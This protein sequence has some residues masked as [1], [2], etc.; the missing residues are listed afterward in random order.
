MKYKFLLLL[1]LSLVLAF[2]FMT[3]I[4]NRACADTLIVPDDCPTIQQAIDAASPGDTIQVKPGTYFEN[5]SIYKSISLIAQTFDADD[6][7][8]NV[9]IIDS[10]EEN[11]VS[12][13]LIPEGISPMPVIQGFVIRNG[14]DGIEVRSEAVIENNFFDQASDQLDFEA[15]GGGIVRNNVFF[16]S[17]DD[18]VD[19][20]DLNRPIL[21]ENNRMMYNGDDGIE[22]RLH[23]ETAP[24][25]PVT[26][27]IQNNQIIG[28]QEDGIQIIDYSQNIDTN[29]RFII[30][31]NLIAN[32]SDA[33][34][35][36][37]P[38][39]NTSEDFSGADIIEPV[40]T[41]NNT[42]FGNRYGLSGGDNHVAFNNIFANSAVKAVWRVEGQPEDDSIVAYS[43]FFNNGTDVE[44]SSLGNGNLFGMDPLFAYPP[45][46]GPDGIWN[47]VDDDFSGL[48]LRFDSPAI[49]AGINQIISNNGEAI[50]PS[51]ITEFTGANPDLGWREYGCTPPL[52]LT[53]TIKPTST[54]LNK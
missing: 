12:T 37:M 46:A 13:I 45:N 42:F 16:N 24:L 14:D 47:T 40:Y 22:I 9:T 36:M 25:E 44:E 41:Y 33:G 21:I 20:D 15:G 19:L 54:P 53:P 26:A 3:Y 29:R 43:L 11:Q 28:C 8:K 34:I 10:G 18:A 7:T 49:D 38:D 48:H 1:L 23:D 35:G 52:N 27:I 50:P 2:I 17:L 39:A 31:G 5:I 4:D 51:P 6:P 30:K 32:C